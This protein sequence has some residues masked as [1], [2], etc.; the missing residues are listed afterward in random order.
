[1]GKK[2]RKKTKST[3]I[4]VT[5]SS[6][7]GAGQGVFA[8]RTIPNGTIITTYPGVIVPFY[9]A[10]RQSAYVHSLPNQRALV[11]DGTQW[12][13]A[14]CGHMINDYA[15]LQDPEY[16]QD[17]VVASQSRANVKMEWSEMEEVMRVVANRDID[18][19]E[20]LFYHYGPRYWLIHWLRVCV[21]GDNLQEARQYEDVLVETEGWSR[22]VPPEMSLDGDVI[23][24]DGREATEEECRR[25]VF[26]YGGVYDVHDPQSLIRQKLLSV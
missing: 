26:F 18:P 23:V 6:I 9:Q 15:M 25:Y 12:S 7:E 4:Q 1:M 20:E 3:L 22:C 24:V 19:G 11:G 2:S 5:H 17:Y 10:D 8:V 13:L 16:T 14:K 21:E